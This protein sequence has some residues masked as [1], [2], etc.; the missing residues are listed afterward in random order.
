MTA[1]TEQP[2]PRSGLSDY[3]RAVLRRVLEKDWAEHDAALARDAER[4]FL[5][6]KAHR[7]AHERMAAHDA[8][9]RTA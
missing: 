1:T 8:K 3:E 9:N 4:R 7:E 5:E 6:A 2:R